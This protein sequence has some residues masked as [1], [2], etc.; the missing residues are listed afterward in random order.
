ME[1]VTK[2]EWAKHRGEVTDLALDGLVKEECQLGGESV[3]AIARGL[4]LH[5]SDAT[6]TPGEPAK[7]ILPSTVTQQAKVWFVCEGR[8]VWPKYSCCADV[9]HAILSLMG[10]ED[11][12]GIK[13]LNRDD[14]NADGLVDANEAKSQ[15]IVSW[16][17]AM[18]INGAKAYGKLMESE[19]WV[20]GSEK[21]E[22]G[23]CLIGVGDIV[24][25]GGWAG[26]GYEH[27]M[28]A[29]GVK[30]VGEKMFLVSVDGGQVDAGGQCLKVC[31]R[32]LKFSNGRWWVGNR[33]VQGHID[34]GMLAGMMGPVYRRL[35]MEGGEL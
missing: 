30:Q 33:G 31:E 25:V 16:N 21:S 4:A 23:S 17:I 24:I 12:H 18:L 1:K 5:L 28:I 2:T 27:V 6:Q 22:S 10:F 26:G 19:V 20:S 32:E 35:D 7:N 34:I 13:M 9:A 3:Q 15:W 8:Q 11:Q 14:D 29:V